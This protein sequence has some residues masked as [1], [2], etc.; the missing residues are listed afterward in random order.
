[1][2][3]FL[4]YWSNVKPD[5]R[6]LKELLQ[7]IPK[8]EVNNMVNKVIRREEI[9]PLMI[10]ESSEFLRLSI[11]NMMCYKHLVCGN[12]LAWGRVTLYYSR[13]YVVNCLLRLKGFALA[14]LDFLDN[15]QL[16]LRIDRTRDNRGYRM[17]VCNAKGHSTI[18]KRFAELYPDLSCNDIEKFLIKERSD[19][20]Y[21]PFFASQTTS[22]YALKEAEK[23]CKHNFLDPNYG[24]CSSPDA[25]QYYQELM[26]DIGY[27]ERG[28]GDYQKYAIDCFLSIGKGSKHKKWYSAFFESMLQDLRVLSSP[29]ESKQEVATW[30]NEAISQLEQ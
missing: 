12:Y 15:G 4:E 13:F 29:N 20:N 3:S 25:G 8:V 1:M 10:N 14:H 22:R 9:D 6:F 26:A 17:Q 16:A 24:A 21:D 2:E 30:I 18:S 23:R 27:E 11:V 19:W 7:T 28:T 5:Y